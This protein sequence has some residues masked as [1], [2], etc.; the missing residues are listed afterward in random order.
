MTQANRLIVAATVKDFLIVQ[1]K[2]D[3]AGS[4]FDKAI[5]KLPPLKTKKK[6]GKYEPQVHCSHT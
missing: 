3:Q 4:D 2:A 6:G 5:K 1:N